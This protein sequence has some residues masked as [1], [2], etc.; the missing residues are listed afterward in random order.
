MEHHFEDEY[1]EEDADDDVNNGGEF[2]AI[3]LVSPKN[4]QAFDDDGQSPKSALDHPGTTTITTTTTTQ[5][6]SNFDRDLEDDADDFVVDRHLTTATTT[7]PTTTVAQPVPPAMFNNSNDVGNNNTANGT[8]DPMQQQQQPPPPSRRKILRH[9]ILTPLTRLP[10]DR[11]VS[12]AGACDLL[13]NCKYSMRQVE[14]EV[15]AEERTRNSGKMLGNGND[16]GSATSTYA[17]AAEGVE[18]AIH[19]RVGREDGYVN[20]SVGNNEEYDCNHVD[21]HHRYGDEEG[22]NA[23]E[24][25]ELGLDCCSMLDG[26]PEEEEEEVEVVLSP[27][28]N[29]SGAH[30]NHQ[31]QQQKQKQS[32]SIGE[33]RGEECQR[34]QVKINGEQQAGGGGDEGR[35]SATA[36]PRTTARNPSLLNDEQRA[37]ESWKNS[38]PSLDMMF[39]RTMIND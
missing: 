11:F 4:L 35:L 17:Y 22:C 2:V 21:H 10:W 27:G 14:D 23:D 25:A 26:E 34:K 3:E 13:F 20:L 1:E 5:Q 37:E 7:H 9:P 29:M 18:D 24:F 15:R 38:N 33:E 6:A 8:D 39:Y 28:H 36:P 30:R 32:I 16:G 19:D 31:Q 12:A